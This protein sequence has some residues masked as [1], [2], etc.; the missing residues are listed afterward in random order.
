MAP[1]AE[2]P[3]TTTSTA[4]LRSVD[5]QPHVDN[6][7]HTDEQGEDTHHVADAEGPQ[8]HDHTTECLEKQGPFRACKNKHG[9]PSYRDFAIN[10]NLPSIVPKRAK[11]RHRSSKQ[12]APRH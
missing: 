9:S 8:K 7:T 3:L 5:R 10:L 6:H 11:I 2:P 12:K 1:V 4:R